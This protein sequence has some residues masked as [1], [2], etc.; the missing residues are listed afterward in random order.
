MTRAAG[1]ADSMYRTIGQ[2]TALLQERQVVD[3]TQR[4]AAKAVA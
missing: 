3:L 2:A 4:F 1:D